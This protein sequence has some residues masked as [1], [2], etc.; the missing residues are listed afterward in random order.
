MIGSRLKVKICGVTNAEDL[1]RSCELG[2]D[3][4]GFNFYRP[5]PR[6]VTPEAAR[7]LRA[8]MPAGI[9]AVGV[10]VNSPMSEV[11]Q[12]EREVKLDR[13]QFHGDETADDVAP[14]A[15]RSIRALRVGQ[16]FKSKD[17]EAWSD[18]WAVLFDAPSEALYGGSGVAWAYDRVRE[19]VNGSM[20]TFIAGG[21][22][23]HNVAAVSARLPGLEGVD[24]CSGV[25]TNPGRKDPELLREFFE[26]LRQS[27]AALAG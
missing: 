3:L 17:V 6:Y 9:D 12:V 21:L 18:C 24:V 27:S 10:F 26:R 16:G 22:G 13:I 5:S 23:P 1:E 7:R 8:L 15:E 19:V 4:I 25:E 20:R 11:A 14:M 2:A